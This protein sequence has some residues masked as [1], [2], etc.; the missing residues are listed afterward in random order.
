MTM[1][2]ATPTTFA[3]PVRVGTETGITD[4]PISVESDAPT[5]TNNIMPGMNPENVCMM[6]T[7]E[8]TPA[9]DMGRTSDDVLM[10][11]WVG[12]AAGCGT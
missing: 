4:S 1:N 5:P 7:R 3:N 6:P 8:R 2:N 12:N 10:Y 9:F 11:L